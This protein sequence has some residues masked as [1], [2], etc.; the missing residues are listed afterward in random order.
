MA[1]VITLPCAFPYHKVQPTSQMPGTIPFETESPRHLSESSVLAQDMPVVAET[2]PSTADSAAEDGTGH[3]TD[4]GPEAP[5]TPPLSGEETA[6]V[7]PSTREHKKRM[8]PPE[9]LIIVQPSLKRQHHHPYNLQ[10]QLLSRTVRSNPNSDSGH[11]ESRSRSNSGASLQPSLGLGRSNSISSIRSGASDASASSST[12]TARRAI[13]LYNLDFHHIRAT[14]ILDAGTDQNVAKFT[15]R[16]VEIDNFGLLQPQEV[17]YRHQMRSASASSPSNVPTVNVSEPEGPRRSFESAAPSEAELGTSPDEPAK[18][19]R[20]KFFHRIRRLGDHLRGNKEGEGQPALT[21]TQSIRSVTRTNT[22][23]TFEAL[24]LNEPHDATH[25][26]LVSAPAHSTPSVPQLTP[27]AGVANGKLTTAYC[28]EIK[29]LSRPSEGEE[30][31]GQLHIVH[32]GKMNPILARIWKQFNVHNRAGH[33]VPPPPP[34]TIVVRFEWVREYDVPTSPG[35]DTTGLPRSESR[36]PRS[37][38]TRTLVPD[39]D[40]TPVAERKRQASGDQASTYGRR[41][42]ESSDVEAEMQYAPWTCYLVLDDATRI[43]IGQLT[44]APHHPLVVCQLKLPNPLPNLR[45]SGLGLDGRGFSR[46]ELRDI[47]VTTSVHLVIRESLGSLQ[48]DP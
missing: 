13:P 19:L 38:P 16:G 25:S 48:A 12:A 46:E 30:T 23:P 40:T 24:R 7:L 39:G 37:S 3:T 2:E 33:A 45:H 35:S 28:W 41:T 42:S 31:N 17:V 47:V 21:R 43:P 27:G 26:P 36:S 44:P 6:H 34:H 4:S 1:E 29:R 9:E 22:A 5:T 14:H 20:N 10:I 32:G 8:F 15:R 18:V 11:S